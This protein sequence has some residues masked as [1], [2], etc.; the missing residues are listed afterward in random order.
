MTQ[1]FLAYM[2]GV[3]RVG[4][5]VA[6]GQLQRAGLIRYHRGEL[7]VLDRAGL[8]AAACSCY[9]ADC[10]AYQEA[11]GSDPAVPLVAIPA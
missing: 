8:E 10:L 2:L 1:E 6:A 9:Q 3:R 5:T 7:S 4:I 11:L